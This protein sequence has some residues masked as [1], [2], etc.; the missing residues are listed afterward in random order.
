VSQLLRAYP[1]DEHGV[2]TGLVV[3]YFQTLAKAW[4]DEPERHRNRKAPT[5]RRRAT[6]KASAGTARR[7]IAAACRQLISQ[8]LMIILAV[9]GWPSAYPKPDSRVITTLYD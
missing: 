7:S 9:M 6:P 1:A 2:R 5:Q 3:E 4:K 8:G